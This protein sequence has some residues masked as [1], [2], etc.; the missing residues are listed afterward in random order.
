RRGGAAPAGVRNAAP[1][2]QGAAFPG[3]HRAP[4]AVRG[5]LDLQRR[6]VAGGR[7]WSENTQRAG[8]DTRG[9]ARPARTSAGAT[10][11]AAPAGTATTAGVRDGGTASALIDVHAYARLVR[12]SRAVAAGA[13]DDG[14]RGYGQRGSRGRSAGNAAARRVRA[15]D[16]G[17]RKSG[18][19]LGRPT[20]AADRGRRE[21]ALQS[22][23]A[24]AEG[25]LH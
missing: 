14:R 1:Q 3:R 12:A 13:P 21:A 8:G 24:A 16:D 19:P 25:Y 10:G 15:P 18:R 7:T 9:T 5:L 20:G 22:G 11:A 6:D 17:R 4:A 23:H 2:S